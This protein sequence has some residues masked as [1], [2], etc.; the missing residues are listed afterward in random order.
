MAFASA[1]AGLFAALV[2]GFIATVAV[3]VGAADQDLQ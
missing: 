3:A 1:H 2:A